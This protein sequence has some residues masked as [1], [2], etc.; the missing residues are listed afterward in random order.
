MKTH[1]PILLQS[2][3]LFTLFINPN[4]IFAQTDNDDYYTVVINTGDRPDC[5]SFRAKYDLKLDNFLKIDASGSTDVVVKIID[6]YTQECIRCVFISGGD[7]HYIKNIP[8]G[9]YY[10]KIAYGYDWGK[11]VVGSFCF[12]KFLSDA[13]YQI[14]NDLLNYY[15]KEDSNGY[16]VPSYALELRVIAN[17]RNN[18][19]DA[20]NISEE[21]F[22]R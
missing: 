22:Y 17:N 2:L 3:I 13:H 21:E 8:Q 14:G 10:L 1:I 19:F 5:F 15:I 18:D 4:L 20:E 7:S 11:K 16:Q 6:N 12:S 9:I